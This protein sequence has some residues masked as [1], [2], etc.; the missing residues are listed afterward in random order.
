MPTLSREELDAR[1]KALMQ[2][3]DELYKKACSY[4]GVSTFDYEE[5]AAILKETE[6]LIAE[7]RRRQREM[8]GG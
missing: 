3:S 2:R 7:L 6:L 5:N 1:I 8:D 4:E